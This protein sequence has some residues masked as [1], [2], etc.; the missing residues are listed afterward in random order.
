MKPSFG[1]IVYLDVAAEA[2]VWKIR[3]AIREKIKAVEF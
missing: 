2:L 3:F 1:F